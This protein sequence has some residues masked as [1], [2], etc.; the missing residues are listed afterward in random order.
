MSGSLPFP[1]V[2]LSI[3]CSLSG[4]A[5]LGPTYPEP[6]PASSFDVGYFVETQVRDVCPMAF[7]E[8]KSHQDAHYV[9][10]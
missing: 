4:V 1:D 8:E 3:K 6:P 9:M 7:V 2:F 10:M 5:A